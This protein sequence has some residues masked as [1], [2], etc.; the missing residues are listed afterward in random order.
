M[1]GLRSLGLSWLGKLGMYGGGGPFGGG[2]Y[3][4]MYTG[5][6]GL[7]G[8][9]GGLRSVNGLAEQAGAWIGLWSSGI[10][11]RSMTLNIVE[12]P[13]N[14]IVLAGVVQLIGNT[15][16]TNPVDV[17]GEFIDNQVILTGICSG[18]GNWPTRIDIVGTLISPTELAGNYTLTKQ[19][20]VIQ[21]GT[22]E[23]TLTTPVL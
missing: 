16:L 8:I 2:L 18:L 21:T 11:S 9:L 10:S 14:P 6:S 12:D 5:L 15:L 13:V 19:L 22:F 4:S 17:T 3:G 1:S 20:A 23:L 7:G